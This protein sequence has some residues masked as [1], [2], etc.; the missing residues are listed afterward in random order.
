AKLNTEEISDKYGL[1]YAEAETLYPSLLI[2]ANFLSE[3]KAETIIIPMV[4]IQDGLLLE[5]AQLMSGNK[6]ADLSRQVIHSSRNLGK[7][8]NFDE[9][10]AQMVAAISLKLFDALK[11]DHGLGPRERLLLEVSALLH[12]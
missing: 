5:M 2:Y 12:D 3:T 9:T 7:K 8:Y 6:R 10:H 4:S 1:S 11:D